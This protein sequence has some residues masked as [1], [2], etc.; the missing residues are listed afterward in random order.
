MMPAEM[1]STYMDTRVILISNLL[2]KCDHNCYFFRAHSC[3][4]YNPYFKRNETEVLS[5]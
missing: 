3:E 4:L 2:D 1:L 5:I